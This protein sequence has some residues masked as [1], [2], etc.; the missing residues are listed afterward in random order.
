VAP[1]PTRVAAGDLDHDGRLDLVTSSYSTGKISVLL[2]RITPGT[3]SG[4]WVRQDLTVG[5]Q[6]TGVFIADVTGDGFHDLVVGDNES[7]TVK[8]LRG[9]A[10]GRLGSPEDLPS[11]NDANSHEWFLFEDFDKDGL[12]DLL[13]G[14]HRYGDTVTLYRGRTDGTISPPESFPATPNQVADMASVDMNGDGF[15]DVVVTGVYPQ[16]QLSVLHWNAG[17][18]GFASPAII[19]VPGRPYALAVADFNKDG[20]PDAVTAP[21]DGP[22]SLLHYPGNATGGFDSTPAVLMNLDSDIY[23]IDTADL[24]GDTWPDLIVGLMTGNQI[25]ILL[26]TPQGFVTGVQRD[27]DGDGQFDATDEDDDNDG[28]ADIVETANGTDPLK[29]DTD[30]DGLSDSE[31]VTL[32]TDPL[33]PDSDRDGLADGTEVHVF[34][35][36]PDNPDSDGDGLTDGMEVNQ[37]GTNPLL[38]DTDDDG[39]N[40]KCEIELGCDPRN[41]TDSPEGGP[42]MLTAVEFRFNGALGRTY[43]IESST[44]LETWTPVESG[45]AGTG[46]TIARLYSI[47][48]IPKRY[49]RARR[50]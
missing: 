21:I 12:K 10:D 48:G 28:V 44:D 6:P 30:D 1:A 41:A 35:T 5:G 37:H 8:L 26:G 36:L 20:Q 46:G 19:N 18:N 17:Q 38:A 40:D 22:T 43:R 29:A 33:E 32:G 49:F 15:L 25:Q 42:Q 9:S 34:N 47:Q 16:G 24:N 39:F 23:E 13:I 45:V 14:E 7:V 11:A 27:T 4:S 50:D 3:N 31:E 2:N